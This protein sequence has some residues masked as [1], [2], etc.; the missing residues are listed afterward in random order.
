MLGGMFPT[1]SNRLVAAGVVLM[2]SL[3]MFRATNTCTADEMD[4]CDTTTTTTGALTKTDSASKGQVVARPTSALALLVGCVGMASSPLCMLGA[5]AMMIT[6]V[7]A[8]GTASQVT[9]TC[10][11]LKTLYKD[12]A[13]CGNAAKTIPVAML[14]NT[15]GI[16]AHAVLTTVNPCIAK[17][18]TSVAALQNKPCFTNGVI[19]AVEQAG[20]NV[21]KGFQGTLNA[22]SR[23]PI[24][25][26]YHELGL[27]PVNVHWHLGAEHYSKG[28]YDEQG[29]G[30]AGSTNY[31]DTAGRLDSRRLAAG[32]ARKGFQCH[33]YKNRGTDTKFT[34]AYTWRH[35]VGMKVGE[36]YEVHWPHSTAG[37]CGNRWQF[38]TPFYD[39]VFCKMGE[40]GYV[41]GLTNTWTNIGVQAQVFTI[42]ND[43]AY[44]Y[45]S[46]M[47]GM[48][49]LPN[50]DY[51]K[52]MAYYTGSTT[53]TSRNNTV[54]SG[55]APITWQV[56]RKCHL[57]SASSFDKMCADMKQNP[58]DMS[59]D[60]YAHG[61]RRL[62]WQ[63]LSANN[64]QRL[65][66][67]S[68][69]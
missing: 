34:T 3:P 56:D 25:Q 5:T 2:I 20:G 38:Q 59:N 43:E 22:G 7:Q 21:T 60:L 57:I 39:G 41:L 10:G 61:S 53:G 66:S 16:S 29:T 62:V 48:I 33:H 42:V 58:D 9:S 67:S 65:L 64:Q 54:C 69:I 17:K 50:T 30:P 52:D 28:Q 15:T 27:C 19:N 12:N 18:P 47:Q 36:T 13:C 49:R 55:Y 26:Q 51:G 37:S 35:C 68:F 11:S 23:T 1:P 8:A 44:Y 32:T 45:P 40:P 46:L 31:V 4:L 6:S 24:T 63:N 14:P